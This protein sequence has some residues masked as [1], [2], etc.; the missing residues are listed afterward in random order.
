MALQLLI[1]IKTHLSL[2]R[3]NASLEQQTSELLRINE[4]LAMA[5]DVGDAGIWEWDRSDEVRLDDHSHTMLG[6]A[7]RRAAKYRAGMVILPPPGRSACMDGQGP[8]MF[9][10]R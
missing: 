7:T 8:S 9:A 2:S 5:L 10:G 3:A 1:L 4:R 6:Y